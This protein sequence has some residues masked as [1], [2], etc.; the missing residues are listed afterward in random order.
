MRPPRVPTD[1]TRPAQ[2]KIQAFRSCPSR[3][4]PTPTP[5]PFCFLPALD[6]IPDPV[7][8]VSSNTITVRGVNQP[9]PLTASPGTTVYVNDAYLEYFNADTPAKTVKAGDR[10]RV[11][12]SA[13]NK[14]DES[15]GYKLTIGKVSDTFYIVTKNKGGSETH[16]GH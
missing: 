9:A 15:I 6:A 4:A 2:R 13:S 7:R 5:E 3:A 8:A 10:V 1:A 14:G 16:P 12:G 11:L